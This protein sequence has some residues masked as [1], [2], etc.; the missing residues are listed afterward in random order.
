LTVRDVP[1]RVRDALGRA[2]RARGQSLQAFLL[3]VLSRQA[4]FSLNSEILAEV[5]ADLAAGGGASTDAPDAATLLEEARPEH[6]RERVSSDKPRRK[7][8]R[9]A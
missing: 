2:A 3:S 4:D 9:V 1:E 8:G 5:A 6:G 7:G